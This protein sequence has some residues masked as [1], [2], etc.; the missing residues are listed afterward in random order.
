M[1]TVELWEMTKDMCPWHE[2]VESLQFSWDKRQK[3]ICSLMALNMILIYAQ[4]V[5]FSCT[6]VSFPFIKNFCSWYALE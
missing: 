6:D 5:I 2:L 3:N 4:A 1:G